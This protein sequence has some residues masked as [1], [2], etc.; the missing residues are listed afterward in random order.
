LI[1]IE[2]EHSR[3]RLTTVEVLFRLDGTGREQGTVIS[4]PHLVEEIKTITNE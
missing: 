4:R 3:S 2:D 1:H